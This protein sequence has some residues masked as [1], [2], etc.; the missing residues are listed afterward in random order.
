MNDILI[1]EFMDEAAVNRLRKSYSVLW[2]AEL[3]SRPDQLLRQIKDCRALIVRNRTQVNRALINAA[4][5]LKVVARLGVGLDNIDL[6]ACAANKIEVCPAIGSNAVSVA[7]YVLS[8]AM[9]L[10]RAGA[11]SSTVDLQNGDWPRQR[12]SRGREIAGKILGVVGYGS[13]GQTTADR[14]RALGMTIIAHDIGLPADAPQWLRATSVPLQDLL[15]RADVISLHCPLTPQ[16]T[17][18]IDREKLA[19]MKPGAILINAARGGIVDEEACAAALRSGH[20]GGA[21]LDVFATEPLN[22]QNAARFRELDNIILTPHIAGVTIEANQRAS[23]LCAD[24]VERV[25]GAAPAQ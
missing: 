16:T 25:L 2:D 3:W 7:E 24:H 15:R 12:L 6:E 20:L 23:T 1:T 11:F 10:L 18:L 9:I 17:N 5:M 14:A 4:P 22:E 8:C 19:L 21:A 13:I